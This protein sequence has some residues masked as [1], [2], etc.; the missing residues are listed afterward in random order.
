MKYIGTVG[1]LLTIIYIISIQTLIVK[2]EYIALGDEIY[3]QS[4]K[5]TKRR[6]LHTYL[7]PCNK[8]LPEDFNYHGYILEVNY[9]RIKF[10]KDKNIE[11]RINK[12]IIEV[13]GID[14]IEGFY[15]CGCENL[16]TFEC[17]AFNDIL[18]VTCTYSTYV[19]GAAHSNIGLQTFHF[20]MRT[21]NEINIEDM[22]KKDQDWAE[23]L[24]PIIKEELKE[25]EVYYSEDMDIVDSIGEWKL[26]KDG[27]ELYYMPYNG[28]A[29]GGSFIQIKIPY[30]RIM[31]FLDKDLIDI[32]QR[33]R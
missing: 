13:L 10:E 31:W 29:P 7:A 3:V 32:L 21:G 8:L 27:M 19:C 11:E 20:D 5:M 26:C 25:E 16:S 22:L 1:I 6:G 12:K 17:E 23:N 9:P 24:Y 4:V 2:G 14:D 33:D 15:I 28:P 30:E 18:I